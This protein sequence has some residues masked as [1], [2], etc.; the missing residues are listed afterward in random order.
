MSQDHLTL[1]AL[2]PAQDLAAA[3]DAGYVTRKS[4]PELPLSIY[5]YTRTAQYEQVWNQVT[6]RCRGLV[7]D[8]TT[9][10]IVALPL[11]KFFNVGEHESGQPYAPALPDEPFEVYDKVDGSL[12]VVFHYADRWRV[13]SKG[14]FISTQATWAQRRLDGLD[15]SALVPGVTYL[16]EILYPQNRIVV[17]YGERRDLVLLAAFGADGTEVPLAEAAAHWAPVGA[18]VKVWPAMPLAELVALTEANTLLGGG[19]STGTDAEGYVLR[20]AS[21]VRAK[22]KIAEYVR[23]HRVLTGVN[24]RDIWRSH[25]VQRFAGLP[26]KELA[27]GLQCT[28]ADLQAW[29]GKPLDAL[30]AQVPD[31]FD[32]WVRKVIDRLEAAAAE[33]ERTIDE[34]FAGLAHL[35]ADRG[36]FARA[37]KQLPA[38]IL[39]STMFLRLDGKSTELVTWRS[40]RPDTSVPF[41]T[42]EENAPRPGDGAKTVPAQVRS[43]AAGRPV[44]PVAARA[45]TAP[46]A[47]ASSAARPSATGPSATRPSA[48]EPGMATGEPPAAD[49]PPVRPLPV[50]HVMTGLPASGK[51]TAAR[52]LQ[53]E[54]GGRMRRVNLDDLR[55]M[56]DGHDHGRGHSY[57][58][59]QTVLEIQDA[60]LRAAVEGGFDVVVDNTHLTP[61]IPKRLK[62]AVGGRATFVV[63]DFTDVPLEECLRRDAARE[64][65]V[66]EEIIRILAD[67][68]AKSRKGGWKLTAEWLNDQPPVEPYVADPSLP[69]AVMCDIDGT[70]ALIGDRGPYDF[71]RCELDRLND[72][73][74][75]ALDAFR[76]AHG[77]VIVLLSGRGEE[78][79]PQT[80]SWLRRHQVPYDELWMRAAG[81]TRRDDVVKAELFDA[82]VRHRYAVRVSLDDR[83]RVVA[84]WRRM[85]LP[86]WQVNYGDF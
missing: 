42:D 10:R 17:D 54:S 55:G 43:A 21:G 52:A 57:K 14:S 13:A 19:T 45:A 32:A 9:G 29:G 58:H 5:T 31:E 46:S 63:H 71:T 18:V 72:S 7:A 44:T 59:E 76:R 41:L 64:R 83:D 82:H 79:R 16:A 39:R 12:A 23:L 78:H 53:A 4:H 26:A 66:G 8:D 25:G 36:A 35:A 56:L 49:A 37:A 73:V 47:T 85:G 67:K 38:G 11:P 60:A 40:L 74:R 50:V 22:A 84:V 15:T 62:A 65:Q 24:E 6:R 61:N 33:R 75:G 27:Q 20:F 30:L 69:S 48:D 34:A 3:I 86:T 70:L 2:L 80:E 51:T 28:V 77:D 81:D 68:H 1:H